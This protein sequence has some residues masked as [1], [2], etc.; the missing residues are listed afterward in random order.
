SWSV[1]WWKRSE[2][3]APATGPLDP[4][5]RARDAIVVLQHLVGGHGQ[6]VDADEVIFRSATRQALVEELG[7]GDARLDFDIVGE[8]CAI[9]VDKCHA[10]GILLKFGWREISRMG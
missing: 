7:N 9:V 1:P 2:A 6:A 10:H 3:S 5:R 8:A 4:D